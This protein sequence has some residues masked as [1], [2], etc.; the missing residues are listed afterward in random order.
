MTP[1]SAAASIILRTRQAFWPLV[2]EPKL[3]SDADAYDWSES[4]FAEEEIIMHGSSDTPNGWL[5][6]RYKDW[7]SLLTDAVRKG[8]ERGKAPSDLSRWKYGDWHVVD[9]EHPLFERLPIVKSWSGTGE[10]PLSGDTTTIKQVGRAFGPSQR[11]TMD[12][13]A[14]DASTENIVLGESGNPSSPWFRDQWQTYYSGATFALPFKPSAVTAQ[15]IHTLQLV[16]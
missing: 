6:S 5:P 16:P 4:N 2:L 9:L 7:D 12:W 15:T 11:F 13:S 1:D 14:P 8:L 10:L 3:G